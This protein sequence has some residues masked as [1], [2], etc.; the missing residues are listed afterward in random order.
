MKR[1][2]KKIIALTV[3]L[4]L[5]SLLYPIHPT[6]VD[7][8]A[9]TSMSATLSTL[10]IN[11]DANQQILFTTTTGLAS[12]ETIILTYDSDFA[13]TGVLFTDIDLSFDETP[14]GDPDTGDTE[15]AIVDGAPVTV[16]MG[17]VNTSSTLLTFTNGSVAVAAGG[18]ICIQIGTNAAGPGVNM[19]HNPTSAASFD[20]VISGTMGAPDGGT[21]VITTVTDDAVVTTATVPSRLSFAIS[22]NDI[23]FGT[24]GTGASKWADDTADGNATAAVGHT[25]T[26]STNSLTGY[27]VTVDG[28][29]LKSTATPAHEITAMPAEAALS[30]NTEQ[31]GL[32]ITASGGSCT[33]AIDAV[34][35]NSPSDH[36]AL[37]T[38]AFPDTIVSCSNASDDTVFSIFYAANIGATTE[39]H[40]DYTSTLTYV[41]TGN[42]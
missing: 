25:L 14:D 16:S 27:S 1:N 11:T 17:F 5:V 2:L 3:I 6:V 21:I 40:T 41:A 10:K 23:F 28:N 34:Y 26:A 33:G 15:M 42:F 32:R 30:T 12:G 4:S 8:A 36:Y 20:L 31:F 13:T 29:T 9:L 18:E 19:I 38:A 22:D 7:A 24:L 35:D 39:A 37:V